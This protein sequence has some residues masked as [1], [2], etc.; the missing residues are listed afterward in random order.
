[1]RSAAV[2]NPRSIDLDHAAGAASDESVATPTRLFTNRVKVYPK[3]VDGTIR[4]IKWAVL[5]VCLAVYYL[6]PWIR[7]DRGFGRPSQAV[8]IDMPNRRGYF[9]WIE[10]W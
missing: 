10:I 9:F 8:L 2:N 3:K 5:V 1:M 4:Q 6:V 7:W